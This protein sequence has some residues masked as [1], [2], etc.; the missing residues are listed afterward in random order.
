MI[1][2]YITYIDLSNVSSGS[3]VRPAAMYQAFVERGYEVKLLSGVCGRGKGRERKK[4]VTEILQWLKHNRPDFCYIESPT[5]PILNHCDYVL[6]ETLHKRKIPTAYFYRDFYRRFPALFP[7]RK[8]L[9]NQMKEAYLDY[10]QWRTDKVLENV[11]IVYFPSPYCFPYFHYE[12]MKA[13]PPAG[14]AQFLESKGVKKTCIYVGGLSERYGTELLFNTFALLNRNGYQYRLILVGRVNDIKVYEKRIADFPWIEACH[15]SGT[16]LRRL[17][18][19]ADIGLLPLKPIEYGDF[20]VSVKLFEY[21][22]YGLPVV[23]TDVKA[24]NDLITENMFGMTTPYDPNEFGAAIRHM[25]DNPTVLAEYR[26]HIKECLT[27]KHL[28]VHRVDQ[29]CNDLGRTSH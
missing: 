18:A 11:D 6:I 28:W 21:L 23:S 17:Y 24:M 14:K 5:Y 4:N 19:Q 7:R 2:L 9:L 8:G 26:K 22:G 16:E 3:G 13:L 29:I 20:A 25:L 15:A 12:N 1:V 10:L 27:Q